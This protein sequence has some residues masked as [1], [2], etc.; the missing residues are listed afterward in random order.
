M[1]GLI[2]SGRLVQ[3]NFQ[4]VSDTQFV[5]TVEDADNINHLVIFLTGTQPFPDGLGG[6]VYF[7]WPDPIA[8]PSWQLLGFICNA[9]PSAIFKI[10]KLKTNPTGFGSAPVFGQGL[11]S[12]NAQIGISIEPLQA[13]AALTPSIVSEPSKASTFMEFA[14]KTVENLFDYVA[15]FAISQNQMLPNPNETFIPMSALRNWYTNFERKLQHNPNFW[16]S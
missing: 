4:M 10:T 16:K 12:H 8:P 2:V 14:Q 13:I 11:I 7:S 1:F 5:T 15:S 3:T 6:S 9:K